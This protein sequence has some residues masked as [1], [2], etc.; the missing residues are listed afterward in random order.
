[1]IICL[2]LALICLI[3]FGVFIFLVI[4]NA[5]RCREWEIFVV[6]GII[7]SLIFFVIGGYFESKETLNYKYQIMLTRG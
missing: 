6:I 2:I 3:P 5:I 7:L 1:M 4:I